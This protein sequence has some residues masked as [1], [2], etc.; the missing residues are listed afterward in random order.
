MVMVAGK[1][2]DVLDRF[3]ALFV[4]WSVRWHPDIMVSDQLLTSPTKL[5]FLVMYVYGSNGKNWLN[6]GGDAGLDT[7]SRSLFHFRQH[8]GIVTA[9]RPLF[10]VLTR[11]RRNS[12][13][14]GRDPVDT[15]IH[16][17]LNS[18][19]S[20]ITFGRGNQSLRDKDK[21]YLALAEVCTVRVLSI[22]YMVNW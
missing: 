21:V 5:L 17:S 22:F 11:E 14:F 20:L 3:C 1:M 2:D 10:S 13:H 8:C 9:R 16:S 15:R 4:Y 7:D 19:P 6:F 18:N 12:L